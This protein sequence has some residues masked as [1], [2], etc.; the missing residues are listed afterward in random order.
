M[1]FVAMPGVRTLATE[2]YRRQAAAGTA[3]QQDSGMASFAETA[4]RRMECSDSD[5]TLEATVRRGR[6]LGQSRV[7]A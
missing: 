7:A 3:Q 5:V 1:V 4:L 6:A 2:D